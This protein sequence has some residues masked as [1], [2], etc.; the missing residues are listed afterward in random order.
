MPAPQQNATFQ[1][2]NPQQKCPGNISKII[3]TF[4]VLCTKEDL[5]AFSMPAKCCSASSQLCFFLSFSSVCFCRL[6]CSCNTIDESL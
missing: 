5:R 3:Q 4:T 2:A 1:N 6:Y